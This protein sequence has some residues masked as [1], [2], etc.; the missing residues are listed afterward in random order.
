MSVAEARAFVQGEEAVKPVLSRNPAELPP[1][2]PR[3]SELPADH[4][5]LADGIL[6]LHQ[7][8]WLED[9]SDLKIAEKGR[10]TGITYA[11][12]L[13]DTIIAASARGEGG[14]NV[15]YIGDTKDKGREFIGYVAHFAR[16]VAK[17]LT[18]IEEFMFEDEQADGSKKF[19][20]AYRV[21][22]ASGFRVEALSSNPANIRGL[23]G[24]VVIDEAAYHRDVRNV[25]DAVNALLI[26]GGKVR[27]ISTHNG[28][29][30]PFNELIREAR[31]GK[32]PFVVHH[33]PFQ[34]AVDNG[35]YRRVCLTRNWTY[36]PEAEAKWERLIRGSYGAR[37]AA[38]KQELDAIPADAEGAAL[39]RVVIERVKDAA[40]PVV[41]LH[42]PDSFKGLDKDVRE[43]VIR[44][45]CRQKLQ[46]ILAGLDK[47]RAHCFGQDFA[48]SGDV[49]AFKA[50]EI[51]QDT[52]RRCCLVLEL[53]NVPYEAQRDILFYV[54]D[55]LPRLSGGALDATG[56][57]GYLAEVAA[58]RWGEC[59]VEVK[60]SAEWYR[61]NSPRYIEAF[62][63]QTVTVA[64]DEDVIRD[65]QALQYVGGIIKVPDDHRHKGE[66][67]LDRH[68]D[69]AIAGIL[70]WF[71]SLQMT[72]GYGYEPAGQGQ[73]SDSRGTHDRAE[74]SIDPELRGAL[75]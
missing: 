16:I 6:M 64:A 20:S 21:R 23:Q 15:F 59:I 29:L 41:R 38:M 72:I 5:P 12:A 19:I 71:A 52:V 18:E 50:Y 4:D 74:R 46:P 61:E 49:S 14:D 58:Q 68:G 31:A 33:I 67:G 73:R 27:I 28:V 44:D 63:D 62:G 34:A 3:G 25:V 65:H 35:L 30:N 13:D 7:K 22:F 8:E 9:R 55:R 24:I 36:T 42:L 2:L 48:R 26:W 11:E 17:E 37:E 40:V 54:G 66:D 57:G 39:T 69:T 51:G 75:W 1:E 43:A 32:S 56:N 47:Q 70:A 45:F 60:L 10:R 53:R